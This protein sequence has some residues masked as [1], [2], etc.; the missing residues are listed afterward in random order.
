MGTLPQLEYLPTLPAPP[1]PTAH[2]GAS[3]CLHFGAGHQRPSCC[4]SVFYELVTSLHPSRPSICQFF[5][6][7]ALVFITLP[8]FCFLSKSIPVPFGQSTVGCS[9]LAQATWCAVVFRVR[10]SGWGASVWVGFVEECRLWWPRFQA[11]AVMHLPWVEC[12][13]L[14]SLYPHLGNRIFTI[15]VPEAE[16]LTRAFWGLSV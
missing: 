11:S 4:S 5:C 10:G 2:C 14:L 8:N 7:G 16:N 12:F 3:S 1:T 13:T 6:M 15:P 9:S